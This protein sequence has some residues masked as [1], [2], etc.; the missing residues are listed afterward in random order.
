MTIHTPTA[1]V[2]I[3][4]FPEDSFLLDDGR[5]DNSTYSPVDVAK[6][7]WSVIQ[8]WIEEGYSPVIGVT[9]PDGSKHVVDLEEV[10]L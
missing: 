5:A 10:D 2:Q 6:E 4:I 3:D 9:M 8:R 1:S 7:A